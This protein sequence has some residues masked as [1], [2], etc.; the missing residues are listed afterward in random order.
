MSVTQIQA[1]NEQSHFAAQKLTRGESRKQ[2]LP[3]VHRQ[4]EPGS[5]GNSL[6]S[7]KINLTCYWILIA[8]HI[9]PLF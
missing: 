2:V 5:M 8:S 4:K 6:K 3:Y 1:K 9:E 7:C